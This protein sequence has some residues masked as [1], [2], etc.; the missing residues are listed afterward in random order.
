MMGLDDLRQWTLHGS[1]QPHVD[2]HLS[3]DTMQFVEHVFPYLVDTRKASGGGDVAGV[4]FHLL[5][6]T[7][8]RHF[9]PIQLFDGVQIIPFE[10]LHKFDSNETGS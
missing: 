9:Q 4:Q 8:P 5:E 3:Q 10:G 6:S 7:A 1:I 2:V